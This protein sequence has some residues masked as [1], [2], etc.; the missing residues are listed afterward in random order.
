[1]ETTI[2]NLESELAV[3]LAERDQADAKVVELE[4][5][6]RRLK[7]KLQEKE[8]IERF[9]LQRWI[10][11]QDEVRSVKDQL[12]KHVAMNQS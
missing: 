7:V 12:A 5:E 6:V 2:S 4:E 10:E 1:M 8:S 9:R 11:L 3:A